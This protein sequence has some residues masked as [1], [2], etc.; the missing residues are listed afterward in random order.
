L[1]TIVDIKVVEGKKPEKLFIDTN[2]LVLLVKSIC[3]DCGSDD[4]SKYCEDG[5]K[6]VKKGGYKDY[7]DVQSYICNGCSKTFYAS[8]NN[9]INSESK[10][11]EELTDKI[12]K[13]DGVSELSFD[14]IAI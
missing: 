2:G 14:K 7:Y 12:E 1:K 6:L 10:E 13:I 8:F 11:K 9:H 4:Y 3:H 5:R